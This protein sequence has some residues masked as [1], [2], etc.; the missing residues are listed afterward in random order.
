MQPSVRKLLEE[1]RK[2]EEKRLARAVEDLEY[3]KDN[4]DKYGTRFWADGIEQN[5]M[6]V[7]RHSAKIAEIAKALEITQ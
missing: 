7:D 6:R 2:I 3:T 1:Y 5:Q 4:A